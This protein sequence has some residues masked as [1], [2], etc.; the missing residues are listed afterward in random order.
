MFIISVHSFILVHKLTMIL[1]PK[2][3]LH[4]L[5]SII[6]LFLWTSEENKHNQMAWDKVTINK[7]TAELGIPSLFQ[8]MEALQYKL[9]WKFLEGK[10]L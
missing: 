2:K 6:K 1:A 10:G 7:E 4:N 8:A 3:V 5:E 9:A